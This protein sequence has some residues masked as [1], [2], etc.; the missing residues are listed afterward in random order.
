VIRQAIAAC[1]PLIHS[2]FALLE[3]DDPATALGDAWAVMLIKESFF[4]KQ[5]A[6]HV[7]QFAARVGEGATRWASFSRSSTSRSREIC[8]SYRRGKLSF[9]FFENKTKPLGPKGVAEN[10]SKFPSS[11]WGMRNKANRKPISHFAGDF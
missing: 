3:V 8:G 11:F 4:A 10:Y 7:P 6:E 5:K 2:F 9:R 1:I